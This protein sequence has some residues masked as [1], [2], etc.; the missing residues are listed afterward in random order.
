[1]S[2]M[3]YPTDVTDERW[4]RI[5]PYVPRPKPSGRPAKYSRCDVVNAILYQTRNG[6]TWR[7][8]PHDLPSYRIVFHY[9]RAWER[10]GTFWTA[11]TAPYA[12]RCAAKPA[13]GPSP[14]R[15]SSTASR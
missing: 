14:S 13:G 7:S 15:R 12:R 6:C 9:F 11:C 8:L 10:D 3:P 5:E 2:R 1:M 4:R